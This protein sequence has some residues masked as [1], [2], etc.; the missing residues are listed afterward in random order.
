[1]SR[2]TSRTSGPAS[3]GAHGPDR[4]RAVGAVRGAAPPGVARGLAPPGAVRGSAP[5]GAARVTF[6]PSGL[7]VAAAP[8]AS[9]LDVAVA[10]DVAI[11]APCG[12][13]GRCGRCKV[14]IREDGVERRPSAHLSAAEVTAGY[15]LAC[16]ATIQGDAVVTVPPPRERRHRPRGHAVAQP[17]AL[18]VACDWRRDPAVRMFDLEIEPPSLADNTSDFDRLQRAL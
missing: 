3:E 1:M 14:T 6:M 10:A 2:P 17:E 9:L 11:D 12:G 5:P 18:P 13:Q 15:A 7:T 4:E 8:G 16:Q